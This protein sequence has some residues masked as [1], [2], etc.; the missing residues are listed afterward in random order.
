MRWISRGFGIVNRGPSDNKNVAGSAGAARPLHLH[1]PSPLVAR[2]RC[3]VI[4]E[5]E[6][7]GGAVVGHVGNI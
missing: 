5:Q 1:G 3:A 6:A 4:F 7:R 2:E